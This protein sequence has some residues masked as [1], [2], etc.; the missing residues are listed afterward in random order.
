MKLSRLPKIL[1]GIHGPLSAEYDGVEVIGIAHDSRRM[2]PGYV[3]VAIPGHQRDGAEFAEDA[4][5]RG[6]I[7]VVAER[8]LRL[9]RDVPRFIVRDARR[10]LAALANQSHGRPSRRLQVVGVTG[11]N[12][13]TTTTFML[14]SIFEAA[15]HRCGL[16]GTICYDTGRRTL[17]A[18][19]TTPESVDIQEFL[20]E[21]VE[22]GLEYA[23]VEVSSHA[24]CMRRVDFIQFAAAI[25]TNLSPEHMDYHRTMTAYREA[26]TRL[27]SSLGPASYAV[28]NADDRNSSVMARA[29]CATVRRYG[30]RGSAHVCARVRK[31]SLDSITAGI[32]CTHGQVEVRIPLI[33]VHNVYNALGAATAALALGLD[34]DCIRN[35]LERTPP[36]PGRLEPV[37]CDKGCKVLVDYA[38]TDH[39]LKS[40]L[41]SL[42][43]LDVKRILV[44]FGAGGDR[45]RTKRPRMG[46]VVE[47][48]ADLAWIT[49]DNPRN[50]EPLDIIRD[51]LSGVRNRRRV[52]VQPDR[53]IAIAEAIQAARPGDLV[54]IAGKGHERSQRFRDTVVPFDDR[55]AVH[56]ALSGASQ[57]LAAEM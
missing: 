13:K 36:V 18:S 25:F 26:K 34:L 30:L 44:V 19:I 20:A 12:G 47:A 4:V 9:S 45:D 17:P 49:S 5:S 40:V 52:H 37:P 41:R 7:A 1:P 29:T 31:I 8:E 53:R 24:M 14:K 54:L 42:R 48:G 6:A 50:E 33:G 35:G 39:A 56:W 15:G 23:A 3:F 21:M 11:T 27:F 57:D 16:L 55:E 28:V 43:R 46:A 32:S 10:A 2:R 51:I 38:H 22:E